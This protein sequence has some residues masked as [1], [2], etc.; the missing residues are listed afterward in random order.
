[1]V[2]KPALLSSL[3]TIKKKKT[4]ITWRTLCIHCF[5]KKFFVCENLGVCW[6]VIEN[7]YSCE[8]E[9]EVTSAVG[10]VCSVVRAPSSGLCSSEGF[11]L[12]ILSSS[13]KRAEE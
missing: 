8:S 13:L 10:G 6:D 12:Q 4:F 7:I 3:N 1:M 11:D 2:L 9:S 5:V